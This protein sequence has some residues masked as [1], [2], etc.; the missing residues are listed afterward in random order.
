MNYKELNDYELINYAVSEGS[1]EANELIYQKYRPII[2]SMAKKMLPYCEHGGLDLNDLIQEG[3]LGLSNAIVHFNEQKDITFYTF[4]CTCMKRKMISAVVGTRR[5]KHKALNESV[6][7]ETTGTDMSTNSLDYL[8]KDT[9]ADPENLLL[10]DERTQILNHL[11]QDQ[12]TDFELQVFE[13][14]MNHFSYEEI[15][16]IL[17]KNKKAVDNALQ[18]VKIK[19]REILKKLD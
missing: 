1:E 9:S 12:L 18:R 16:Q 19:I 14:K 13:L 2:I 5:L 6:P 8:L 3:M 4:A 7:F 17:D 10:N 15:A 11:I